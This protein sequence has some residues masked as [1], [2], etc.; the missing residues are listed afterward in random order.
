MTSLIKEK[1]N[2]KNEKSNEDSVSVK[3]FL[4]ANPFSVTKEDLDDLE[5]G[6][7]I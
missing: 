6:N 5:L 3:A 1:L 7:Y 2:T 4:S